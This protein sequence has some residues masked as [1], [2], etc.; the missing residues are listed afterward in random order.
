MSAA[1][2]PKPRTPAA[3][4]WGIDDGHEDARGQW[5]ETPPAAR[6]AIRTAMGRD[7]DGAPPA[8]QSTPLILRGEAARIEGP[9]ELVLEDGRRQSIRDTVPPGMPLGYH[10]L[11]P[12]RGPARRVIVAPPRCY[13][14]GRAWGWAVQLYAARS[15]TSWGIGDLADLRTIGEWARRLGAGFLLV[16]PLGATAPTVPQ[17]ASPYRPSSR[18]FKSVLYLRLEEVPGFAERSADLA[19]LAEAG[20]RLDADRRID[21]DAVL[22][23]KL[24]ALARFWPHVAEA[25]GFEA[26]RR[27]MGAPLDEF[28]TYC[29]LAERHGS[30]WRA[31]PEEVRHPAGAGIRGFAR[32]HADRVRFHASVQWLL[33]EQFSRASRALPAVQDLAIGVDPDGADAWAWQDQLALDVEV[34]APPDLFNAAGQA[35]GLPPFVPHKLAAAGYEPFIATLRMN[36]RHAGGLRID[37]AM[38]LFRLFWIPAGMG[39]AEGAYVRYPADDL[40]AIVALESARAGAFVVGEDLGTVEEAARDALHAAGVLS[41][42][43]LWFE[44]SHPRDYP[45]HALAAV[46][47]HDLPTIRGLW[48]GADLRAQKDLGLEPNEVGFLEI[49][50]RLAGMAHLTADSPIEDVIVR[51]HGLL[52]RSAARLRVATLEDALAVVE[53]P[54]MPGAPACWPNWS[55]ALPAPIEA[56]EHGSLAR[57]IAAALGGAADEATEA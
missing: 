33:D 8:V 45:E 43:L 10:W 30:R 48:T 37:H 46:T 41:Y 54:N 25:P 44:S 12:R 4:A 32:A 50:Q 47:T 26:Y 2:P 34:G 9:A 24:D 20:R 16:N 14:P 55:L 23:L 18:R 29:A 57:V 51:L 39:P 42:R 11:H 1:D 36:L 21:R 56:L 3:D 27:E 40:L 31:W 52:G 7:P 15:R 49:Q 28:A 5:R 13:A 35:W 6:R 38:G 22:R 19:A 53:R 17:E